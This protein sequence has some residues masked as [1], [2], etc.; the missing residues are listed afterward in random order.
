MARTW[1]AKRRSVALIVFNLV[2]YHP[3]T[4]EL[5]LIGDFYWARD[6]SKNNNAPS[7]K[8]FSAVPSTSCRSPRAPNRKGKVGLE[9]LTAAA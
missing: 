5:G 7:R 6:P 2:W 4:V 9:E 8:L 1:V 3:C